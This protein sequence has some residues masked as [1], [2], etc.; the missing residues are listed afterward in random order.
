MT[1][2]FRLHVCNLCGL[3]AIANLRNNTFECKGC[4]NK[5]QISQVNWNSCGGPPSWISILFITGH[6]PLTLNNDPTI[7]LQ[8]KLPYAAKL[9]FQELMSMNIAPR[10]M[11]EWAKSG[12][13]WRLKSNSTPK[14]S[15]SLHVYEDNRTFRLWS[16]ENHFRVLMTF[17]HSS[18]Y[19]YFINVISLGT[20]GTHL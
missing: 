13:F 4:K 5:T 7:Q 12:E 15:F 6:I 11:V 10:L 18:C 8:V 16:A 14:W 17:S 20:M 3:I 9:L 2:I 1:M 19:E